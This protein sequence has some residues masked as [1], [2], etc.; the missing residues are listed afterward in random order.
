MLVVWVFAPTLLNQCSW[1]H[2]VRPGAR[3]HTHH[4]TSHKT[5]EPPRVH[6][7]RLHRSH[8]RLTTQPR[9]ETSNNLRD[10]I[11]ITRPPE[12]TTA[13]AGSCDSPNG[14]RDVYSLV[15]EQ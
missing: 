2:G 13:L 3:G 15:T 14:L 6:A 4:P 11:P 10:H 7:S 1:S 12:T 8:P 5:L 9:K